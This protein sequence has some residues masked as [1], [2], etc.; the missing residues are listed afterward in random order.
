V[1]VGGKLLERMMEDP[2]RV[3]LHVYEVHC[4][5]RG[6]GCSHGETLTKGNEKELYE[7]LVI[8]GLKEI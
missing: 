1:R 2:Q 5:N 8:G 6:I 7:L 4:G 3:E